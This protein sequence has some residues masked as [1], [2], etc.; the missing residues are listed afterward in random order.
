LIKPNAQAAKDLGVSNP[1][2]KTAYVP[3]FYMRCPPPKKV[4]TPEKGDIFILYPNKGHMGIVVDA[5]QKRESND[6]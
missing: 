2:P 5:P 3:T 1:L 4:E 6:H